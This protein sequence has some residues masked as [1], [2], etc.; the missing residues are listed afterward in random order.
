MIVVAELLELK[1]WILGSDEIYLVHQMSNSNM[2]DFY[3]EKFNHFSEETLT[4]IFCIIEMNF[5]YPK[6]LEFVD[7]CIEELRS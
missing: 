1:E 7:N 2:I 6:I 4:I 3:R 5:D